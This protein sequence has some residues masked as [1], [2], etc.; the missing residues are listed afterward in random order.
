[1]QPVNKFN[2]IQSLPIEDNIKWIYPRRDGFVDKAEGLDSEVVWLN[3][4]F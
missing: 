1:M 2:I 4:Q 3:L